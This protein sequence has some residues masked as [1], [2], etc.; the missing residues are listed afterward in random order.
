MVHCAA[1]VH[2]IGVLNWY[3]VMV[4]LEWC[5]ASMNYNAVRPALISD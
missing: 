1:L 3:A 2:C 4:Q 5:T